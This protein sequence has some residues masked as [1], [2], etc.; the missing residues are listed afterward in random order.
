MEKK[1]T[2]VTIQR[3]NLAL[4]ACLPLADRVFPAT[5]QGYLRV[6]ENTAGEDGT[7]AEALSDCL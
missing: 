3:Q 4:P 7:Q 2:E 1:L 6:R 5:E